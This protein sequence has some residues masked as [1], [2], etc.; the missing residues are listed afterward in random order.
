M[1]AAPDPAPLR[2]TGELAE[3]V[4]FVHAVLE[5]F[6]AVDEDDRNFVGE[7]AAELFVAVDVDVLPGKAAAAVEFGQ[8]FF[9]DFAEVATFAGVNHDL[10]ECRH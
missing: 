2:S 1:R 9:D 5:G 3:E 10:A 7:L 8:S 4:G 6:V